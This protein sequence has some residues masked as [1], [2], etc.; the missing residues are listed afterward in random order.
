MVTDEVMLMCAKQ[1]E[2][3]CHYTVKLCPK[4]NSA[5]KGVILLVQ[6]VPENF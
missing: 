5:Q 4:L 2:V 6:D 1:A 3:H